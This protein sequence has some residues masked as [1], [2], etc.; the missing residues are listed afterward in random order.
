MHVPCYGV[1]ILCRE[2][3]TGARLCLDHK[4]V[5][6]CLTFIGWTNEETSDLFWGG[7]PW[8]SGEQPCSLGML[9]VW[10][11][12]RS[13][14]PTCA[15][16][17]TAVALCS[18]RVGR[19]MGPSLCP[20]VSEFQAVGKGVN[21]EHLPHSGSTACHLPVAIKEGL[22]RIGTGDV[23]PPARIF[24][25]HRMGH[26]HGSCDPMVKVKQRRHY[27]YSRAPGPGGNIETCT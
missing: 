18:D 1:C 10:N 11:H 13:R 5:P 22:F 8:G 16:H 4:D 2:G 19:D 24:F 14:R 7:L 12:G 20:P 25:Q 26:S 9:E 17:D 21:P 27:G 6:V 23:D 15:G 3:Y